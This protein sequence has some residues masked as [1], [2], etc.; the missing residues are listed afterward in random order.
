MSKHA[1][2]GWPL[3]PSYGMTEACSQVATATPA[4]R[5]LVILDHIDARTESDGRLALRSDAL[6]TGYATEHGF[7]DPKDSE[8]WFITEDLGSIEGR[9]LRVEGRHGDFVKIGGESVDLARLDAILGSIVGVHGA[10]VAVPD[11]RL[12][13][14][15]HLAVDDSVGSD[16]VDIF[17]G[18]VHP[19]ERARAIHRVAEIPR[20]PLG[21][22]MR[23]KLLQVIRASEE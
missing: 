4:S 6:L 5:E 15:V 16:V 1:K 3:L 11:A 17:N 2:L 9:V 20:S 19:F 10:V 22:L 14:V 21:K 13:Q 18:R 8:G 12:G 23:A 7:V